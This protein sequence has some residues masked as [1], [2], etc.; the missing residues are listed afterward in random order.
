MFQ[1]DLEKVQEIFSLKKGDNL[2][3]TGGVING[4]TGNT[5]LLKVEQI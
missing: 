1:H 5:T 4:S 2:V 3:L